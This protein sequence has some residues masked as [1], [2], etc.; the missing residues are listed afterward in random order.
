LAHDAALITYS[1][2]KQALIRA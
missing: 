1:Q 2:I